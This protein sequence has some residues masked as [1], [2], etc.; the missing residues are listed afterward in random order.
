[1]KVI[2][3]KDI[4]E[5]GLEGNIA[6]VKPGYAR[7]YLIPGGLAL[8]ATPQNIKVFEQRKKKIAVRQLRAREDAE[9]LRDELSK[10]VVIMKE[11][12]GE[13]GK[14]YGSVTSMDIAS[15]LEKQGI[16]V[17]RRKIVLESPIK[18]I[19]DHSVSVKIYPGVAAQIKVSVIAQEGEQK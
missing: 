9:R 19:G 11:K 12:A 13:E 14:L 2:L 17:D 15:S 10:V 18:N 3:Q 8:E 5:L 4:D 7:N 6:E 1:M 16:T